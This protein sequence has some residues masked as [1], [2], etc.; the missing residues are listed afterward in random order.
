MPFKPSDVTYDSKGEFD[1]KAG[2][3][4]IMNV[5]KTTI[6]VGQTKFSKTRLLST[7]LICTI[8]YIVTA[9]CLFGSRR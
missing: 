7:E 2:L 3:Y 4:G 6:F 5:V 1:E 8:G 9:R